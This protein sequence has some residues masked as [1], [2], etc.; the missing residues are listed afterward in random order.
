MEVA[1]AKLSEGGLDGYTEMPEYDKDNDAVT[2]LLPGAGVEYTVPAGVDGTYDIYLE[3]G[4]AS[5][6]SSETMFDVIVNDADHYVLPTD[7]ESMD[8][9]EENRF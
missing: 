4:K 1:D 9:K 3:I 7:V 2:N 5:V 8:G 6:L